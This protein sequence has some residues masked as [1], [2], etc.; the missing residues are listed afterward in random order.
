MKAV[1]RRT[2]RTIAWVLGGRDAA[3]FER[4]YDTLKH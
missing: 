1:D 3:T 4:L 2:G